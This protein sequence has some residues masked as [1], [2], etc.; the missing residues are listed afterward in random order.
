MYV[1]AGN[2]PR[3][4]VNARRGLDLIDKAGDQHAR[5]EGLNMLGEALTAAHQFEKAR[6]TFN[7]LLDLTRT[8]RDRRAEANALTARGEALASASELTDAAASFEGS[9]TIF[10]RI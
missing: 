1:R 3:A 4:E 5:A 10:R 6:E 2:T 7:E 8:I 9:L